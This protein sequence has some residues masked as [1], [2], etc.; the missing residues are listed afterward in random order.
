M[1]DELEATVSESKEPSEAEPLKQELFD[2]EGSA[3]EVEEAE[4]SGLT[5]QGLENPPKDEISIE[6]DKEDRFNTKEQTLS[7]EELDQIAD[8]AIEAIR[9]LLAYFDAE[10]AV[11]DEYEGDDGELIL[12]IIGENLA[13]LIGRHGKTLEAFQF[14]I[15]SIV[16]KNI[17]YRYPVVVD[18]EGYKNRRKQK[19]QE[20]AKSS[21]ARAIRQ[22]REVRLRPMTPYERRIIHITLRSDRR[23]V[24]RSEGDEPNRLIVIEAT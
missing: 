9:K 3:E 11:I 8:T 6:P 14:V 2:D 24:T 17:G 16:T 1:N 19:L 21:A 20:L 5:E 12:D 15:S 22:K 13:I 4:E 23:V 18:I 10:D 7:E